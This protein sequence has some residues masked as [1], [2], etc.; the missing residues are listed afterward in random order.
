M[1]Y[2]PA[3]HHRRSIRLKGYDYAQAGAYFVTIVTQDRAWLFG[4]VVDGE[5]QLNDAGTI[6]RQCWLDIPDHFP[7]AVLDERVI[8]PN[9]VHGIIVLMDRSAL[10]ATHASPLPPVRRP[11]GIV[12]VVHNVNRL[13]RLS[14]PS[15]PPSPNRSTHRAA[16]PARPCGN[17]IITNTS[18]ATTGPCSASAHT[19]PRIRCAGHTTVRTRPPQHQNRRTHGRNGRVHRRSRRP[20]VAARVKPGIV[21]IPGT[22][23]LERLEENIGAAEIVLMPGDLWAIE[24]ALAQIAVQGERYPEALERATYVEAPPPR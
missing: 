16:R 6:A 3:K 8:M 9:H 10:G 14:G 18:S 4:G 2:D 15:N 21:P 19:S 13:R 12:R 7:H 1:T 22:R 17:A 11:H 20:R 23:R 24:T 5:M